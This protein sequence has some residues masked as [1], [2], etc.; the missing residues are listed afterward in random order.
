MKLAAGIVIQR[1]NP[2]RVLSI[3]RVECRRAKPVGTRALQRKNPGRVLAISRVARHRAKPVGTRALLLLAAVPILCAA[4]AAFGQELLE[5]EQDKTFVYAE[6]DSLSAVVRKLYVG[7][8]VLALERV[9]TDENAEWIKLSLGSAQ[10]G[11]ARAEHFVHASGLPMTRWRPSS[12]VRDEKPFGVGGGML[13]EFFGPSIKARYL[14][15]TRL[16]LTM[17]GG[18][19]MDG[20]KIKGRSYGFGLVSHLLLHNVSPMVEVGL[21]NIAYHED[22]ST[23]NILGVYTHGGVEWMIDAG[24]FISVGVTFVRSL[25]I[26]VSYSWEDNLNMH[27]VPNTF[28]NVG[29]HISSNT[30]YLFQPSL[31]AGFGF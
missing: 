17:A 9:R 23:L 29:S 16:G 19:V 21:V 13:G 20:Y 18:L 28:G 4:S 30:F 5:V 12:I 7:E 31:T 10:V 15:F 2:G 27:P 1:K 14:F 8:L 24:F 25:S 26:D 11:Y 22:I 3:S 6:P